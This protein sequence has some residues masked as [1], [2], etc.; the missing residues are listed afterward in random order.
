[1]TVVTLVGIRRRVGPNVIRHR[2]GHGMDHFPSLTEGGDQADATG[3][4]QI[5]ARMSIGRVLYSLPTSNTFRY[6]IYVFREM[7]FQRVFV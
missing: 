6:S 3:E 2:L 7:S 1:M 5:A 4:V